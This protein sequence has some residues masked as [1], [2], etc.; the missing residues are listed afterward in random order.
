VH[1]GYARKLS[2]EIG[3]GP[4]IRIVGIEITEGTAEQGKK[5]RFVMVALGANL[6]QLDKISRCLGAQIILPNTGKGISQHNLG[7][8]VQGRSPARDN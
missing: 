8:R 3:D 6:D 2:F 7:K 5:L 1:A 4:Q